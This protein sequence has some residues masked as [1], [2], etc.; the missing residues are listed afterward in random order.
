M[1]II[2]VDNNIW[3]PGLVIKHTVF[4]FYVYII[5]VDN[6]IWHSGIVI[7]RTFPIMYI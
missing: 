5:G 7:K 3:H 4:H 1:Y 6:N 2:V